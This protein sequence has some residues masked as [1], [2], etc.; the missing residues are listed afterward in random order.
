ML[1]YAAVIHFILHKC[2]YFGFKVFERL[3]SSLSTVREGAHTLISAQSS[4]QTVISLKSFS[5]VTQNE[6]KG[7]SS[8]NND[9]QSASHI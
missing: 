3:K 2:V 5:T 6:V 8:L 9:L 1:H 4:L 7:K